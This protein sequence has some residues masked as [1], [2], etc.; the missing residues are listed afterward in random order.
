MG[1]PG[2]GIGNVSAG[3]EGGVAGGAVL[4]RLRTTAGLLLDELHGL[5]ANEHVRERLLSIRARAVAEL[6]ASLP[7]HLCEELLHM[8]PRLPLA[9]TPTPADLCIAEGL[10]AAWLEGISQAVRLDAAVHTRPTRS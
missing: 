8:A 9:T 3:R 6:D 1:F 10:L 2:H 7:D 5:P 4:E